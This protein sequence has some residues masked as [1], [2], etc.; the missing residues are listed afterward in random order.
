VIEAE[1]LVSAS[2]V[3]VRVT[4]GGFGRVEGARYKSPSI[5]PHPAPWH[6]IPV[7]LH[8]TAVFFVPS[9][10]ALTT[11][12][13]AACTVTTLEVEAQGQILALEFIGQGRERNRRC[14]TGPSATI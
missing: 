6:P 14:D 5:V 4:E 2:D 1:T 13:P 9:T 3:A 11:N 8:L 12:D 7:T 10:T